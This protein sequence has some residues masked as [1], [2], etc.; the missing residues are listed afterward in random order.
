MRGGFW[1]MPCPPSSERRKARAGRPARASSADRSVEQID[2]R[3]V[4]DRVDVA[5]I[6]GVVGPMLLN[7]RLGDRQVLG[8]GVVELHRRYVRQGTSRGCEVQRLVEVVDDG[9]HRMI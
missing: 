4:V 3:Q 9:G 5:E 6:A 2:F 7:D 1:A 8:S